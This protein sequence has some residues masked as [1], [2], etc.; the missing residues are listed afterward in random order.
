MTIQIMNSPM[1][2]PTLGTVAQGD[3]QKWQWV[4]I[5][6][7]PFVGLTV[8]LDVIFAF[9]IKVE[10]LLYI[11]SLCNCAGCFYDIVDALIVAK[12]RVLR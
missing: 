3:F 1:G 4:I 10:F 9:C 7:V 11:V 6:L 5:Y 2:L 8:V 12:G